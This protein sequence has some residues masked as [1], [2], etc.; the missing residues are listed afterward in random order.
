[1]DRSVKK[2]QYERQRR[3][4]IAE[5]YRDLRGLLVSL[6][7]EPHKLNTNLRILHACS[8]ALRKQLGQ[9]PGPAS[10]SDDEDDLKSMALRGGAHLQIE[11]SGLSSSVPP[12]S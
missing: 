11:V 10:S 12:C 5:A 9:D 2:K 7:F 4:R 1:M 8:R 6:S 3:D